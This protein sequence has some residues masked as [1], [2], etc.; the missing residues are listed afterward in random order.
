MAAG[1]GAASQR[2]ADGAGPYDRHEAAW[3]QHEV[4]LLATFE[5]TA[6]RL[7][8]RGAVPIFDSAQRLAPWLDVPRD[9]VFALFAGLRLTGWRA[10]RDWLVGDEARLPAVADALQALALLARWRAPRCEP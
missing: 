3:H 10:N 1:R 8:H 5:P 7:R 4:D 2:R 9:E 6:S